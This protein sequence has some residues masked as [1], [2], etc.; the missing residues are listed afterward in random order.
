MRPFRRDTNF[1]S[2]TPKPMMRDAASKPSAPSLTRRR[3]LSDYRGPAAAPAPNTTLKSANKMAS[4]LLGSALGK[5]AQSKLVNAAVG[6]L[7]NDKFQ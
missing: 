3:S 5:F 7:T 2:V 6:R 4:G 1:T